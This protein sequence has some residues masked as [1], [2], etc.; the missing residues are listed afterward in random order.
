MGSTSQYWKATPKKGKKRKI[1]KRPK[2]RRRLMIIRTPKTGRY[3]YTHKIAPY[4]VIKGEKVYGTFS[5]KSDAKEVI[6]GLKQKRQ[7]WD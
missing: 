4:M 1:R 2:R 6:K 3:E 7:M 5:S